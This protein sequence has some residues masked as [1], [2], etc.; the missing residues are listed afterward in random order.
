MRL[1]WSKWPVWAEYVVAPVPPSRR[2]GF[3]N[4]SR[5]TMRRAGY[6]LVGAAF[7]VPLWRWR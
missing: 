5:T 6:R 4:A 7:G 1:D 2:S 3:G